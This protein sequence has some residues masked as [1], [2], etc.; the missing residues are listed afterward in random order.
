MAVHSVAQWTNGEGG[1][2][3]P[4]ETEARPQAPLRV[5]ELGTGVAAPYAGALLASLGALV[6]KLE[7]PDGDPS[8]HYPLDDRPLNGT[9]PLFRYL[10][11]GK[12][13]ATLTPARLQA[14]AGQWADV[15]LDSRVR[16]DVEGFLTERAA[17]GEFKYAPVNAWGF[18]QNDAGD[19]DDELIVQAQSG[20]MTLTGDSGGAPLR[21]PGFQSQFLAGAYTAAGVLA[22]LREHGPRVI[23][24]AWVTAIATGAEGSFQRSLSTGVVPPAA[25]AHPTASFP[26]GA[27][28]CSDGFVVPG[29]V[30]HHDWE[31]QCLLYDQPDL[32]VDPRFATPA[33]RAKNHAE[34]AARIQPWYSKHSRS[35]IFSQA[36]GVGWACG[37]VLGAGDALT[38]AHLHN[39]Q[40]FGPAFG[41]DGQWLAPARLAR[42]LESYT[43][44]TLNDH[45]ADNA[46]FDR[47]I[48]T[49]E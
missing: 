26:A 33:G 37:M 45:G 42:G 20:V 17:A 12:A 13:N 11:V 28:H 31:M 19:I 25:G 21:L 35:E 6:V 22:S 48:R 15:I 29:T 24:V 40:F 44:P 27:F 16:R 41:T 47:Q 30:R 2:L 3:M 43:R 49:S 46:W 5:L 18:E 7:P 8:R 39:R 9:S 10:N 34:L 38:D 4:R 23:E 36:L 1:L 32:V 14:A